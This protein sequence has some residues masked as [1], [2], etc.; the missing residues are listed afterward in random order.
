MDIQI[1][2]TT[3]NRIATQIACLINEKKDNSSFEKRYL[4]ISETAKY[5]NVSYNTLKNKFVPMGL[6][7]ILVDGIERFDKLDCDK[8]MEI[9]KH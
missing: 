4:N 8:F 3:I 7:S 6:K 2:D 9:N 5:M 1:S